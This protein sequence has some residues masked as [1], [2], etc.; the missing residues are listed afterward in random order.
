MLTCT[1]G[2]PAIAALARRSGRAAAPPKS[3][4]HAGGRR[5]RAHQPGHAAIGEGG[6]VEAPIAQAVVSV[7]YEGMPPR[8]A[9]EQLMTRALKAE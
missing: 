7:L 5:G 6:G 3:C 4:E 8:E 1:A 9:V 2:S